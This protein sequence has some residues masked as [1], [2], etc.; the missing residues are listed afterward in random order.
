MYES[1]LQ[2]HKLFLTLFFN[3]MIRNQLSYANATIIATIISGNGHSMF[4]LFIALLHSCNY[5]FKYFLFNFLCI[6]NNFLEQ[7]LYMFRTNT[8][9]EVRLYFDFDKNVC[10]WFYCFF[11]ITR[12]LLYEYYLSLSTLVIMSY[13][14]HLIRNQLSDD[15]AKV[16]VKGIFG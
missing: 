12:K 7:N 11:L 10:S 5:N 1:Y 3:N 9:K 4:V 2:L 16:Y 6:I 8:E 15:F 14:K 13:F